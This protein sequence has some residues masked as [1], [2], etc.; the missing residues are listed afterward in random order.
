MK[1][2]SFTSS[3]C[4]CSVTS[5]KCRKKRD[6]RSKLLF[7]QS[8][9]I[10]FFCRSRC[11]RRH[12]CF[13]SPE[14]TTHQ[15]AQNKLFLCSAKSSYFRREACPG[16]PTFLCTKKQFYPTKM[17]KKYNIQIKR[18]I[19][20]IIII[21]IHFHN[22]KIECLLLLTERNL[23]YHHVKTLAVLFCYFR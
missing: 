6:A 9:A 11:R 10:Y 1:L 13:R 18:I 12:R 2:G 3:G 8:K 5:K 15:N 7:C 21:I 20:K 4:S 22:K 16:P 19:G 14:Q 17:P 23:Y